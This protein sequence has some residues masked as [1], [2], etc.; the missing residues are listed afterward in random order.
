ME[1]TERGHEM[2]KPES[3]MT[4]RE[5]REKGARL[6]QES[7]KIP[8]PAIQQWIEA[9][10]EVELISRWQ[11]SAGNL[12]QLMACLAACRCP[13][14]DAQQLVGDAF[15]PARF[16]RPGR[17]AVVLC[18]RWKRAVSLKVNRLSVVSQCLH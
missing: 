1:H 4:A 7:T 5:P 11:S 3:E 16:L 17:L 14:R 6:A 10:K 12:T 18:N 9:T 13:Q 8:L 15:I 2:E